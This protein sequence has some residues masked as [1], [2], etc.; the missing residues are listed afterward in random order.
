M[1]PIWKREENLKKKPQNKYSLPLVAE[2][3][4]GLLSFPQYI[5]D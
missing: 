1:K 5:F 4:L 3:Q 2:D